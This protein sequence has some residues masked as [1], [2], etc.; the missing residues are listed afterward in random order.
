M[1]G[2]SK[3][4]ITGNLTRDP[5]TRTTTSGTAVCSFSVAVNRR[6]TTNGEQREEVSY[7]NCSAWGRSGETIQQYAHK[8]D[9]ILV[10]GRLRQDRWEDK[11]TGKTRSSIEIVVEEFN[12][13]SNSGNTDGAAAAPAAQKST[14]K[15]SSSKDEVVPDDIPDGEI[16]L[17]EVPF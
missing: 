13:I 11:E 6:Y 9:G 8:G 16:S 4:I 5:E 17:D 1:R 12:F 10:S 14:A 7:F 15:K 3:A 2:F